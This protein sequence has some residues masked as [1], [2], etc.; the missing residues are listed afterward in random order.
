MCLIAD[1]GSSDS[2]LLIVLSSVWMQTEMFIQSDS[3]TLGI[4][5]KSKTDRLQ[6]HT[7]V[8]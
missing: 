7:D 8:A 5:I 3:S 4:D 1:C 2:D 6:I